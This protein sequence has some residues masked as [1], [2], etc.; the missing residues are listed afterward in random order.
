MDVRSTG[1]M[2]IGRT[3]DVKMDG[4]NLKIDLRETLLKDTDCSTSEFGNIH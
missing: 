2:F 1:E 4:V 3:S